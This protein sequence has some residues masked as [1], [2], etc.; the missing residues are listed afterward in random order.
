M[1][2]N[3]INHKSTKFLSLSEF[4]STFN[5]DFILDELTLYTD[6]NVIFAKIYNCQQRFIFWPEIS[7]EMFV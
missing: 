5:R 6:E 2:I 3:Y 4:R 1:K 7:T